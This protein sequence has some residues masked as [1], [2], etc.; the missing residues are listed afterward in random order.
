MFILNMHQSNKEVLKEGT[1]LFL[2]S[3]RGC[4]NVKAESGSV[5]RI[6]GSAYPDP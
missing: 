3:V 5:I 1:Y 6:Y 4:K 2:I